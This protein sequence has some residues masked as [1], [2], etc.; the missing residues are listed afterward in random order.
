MQ[1]RI[2]EIVSPWGMQPKKDGGTYGP[3]MKAHVVLEN[4]EIAQWVTFFKQHDLGEAVEL[5]KNDKG[6]WGEVSATKAAAN[7]QHDEVMKY[8][9]AI[10]ALLGGSAALKAQAP[11]SAPNTAQTAP[12]EATEHE[13]PNRAVQS[14]EKMQANRQK[15]DTIAP[16]NQNDEVD[17]NDIPF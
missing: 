17:L 5:E 13:Y 4:G 2:S 7:A 16:M 9:K 11:T 14:F 10:Y 12:S 15:P 6:Y 3:A 8:L 1:G